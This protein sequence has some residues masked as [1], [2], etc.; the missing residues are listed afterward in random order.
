M[1]WEGSGVWLPLIE[2]EEIESGFS[3]KHN[4][5][6]IHV[7]TAYDICLFNNKDNPANDKLSLK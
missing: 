1:G 2:N 5:E 3:P 7:Y 4:I 6:A